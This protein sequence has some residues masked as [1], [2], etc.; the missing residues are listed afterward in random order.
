[1][2]CLTTFYT[3]TKLK[4]S[5]PSPLIRDGIIASLLNSK[6]VTFSSRLLSASGGDTIR[7]LTPYRNKGNLP[8]T[9]HKF[10]ESVANNYWLSQLPKKKTKLIRK[11]IPS[12]IYR[13]T[14][15][16]TTT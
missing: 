14:R 5:S 15:L 16:M 1:M 10:Y 11:S 3:W 4:R 6:D 12:S 2:G 7:K 13:V 8:P 9:T